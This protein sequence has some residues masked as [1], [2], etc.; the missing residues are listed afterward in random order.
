MSY[1]P[2]LQVTARN[3]ASMIMQ[4]APTNAVFKP[5]NGQYAY[6]YVYPQRNRPK[7]GILYAPE[8]VGEVYYAS[9]SYGWLGVKIG[10]QYGW[11]HTDD[12]LIEP[13]PQTAQEPVFEAESVLV[14][15]DTMT[16]DTIEITPLVD[17]G[18]DIPVKRKTRK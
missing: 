7:V 10:N 3:Y 18:N 9:K 1:Q 17:A 8:A 14:V 5:L 15:E 13:I 11:V 16:E 6:T 4:G 12:M 2:I